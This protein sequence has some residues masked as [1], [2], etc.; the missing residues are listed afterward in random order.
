MWRWLSLKIAEVSGCGS[1]R[2]GKADPSRQS[3][4]KASEVNDGRKPSGRRV[5][6]KLLKPSDLTVGQKGAGKHMHGHRIRARGTHRVSGRHRRFGLVLAAF[7][8]YI[9][10]GANGL[11]PTT[12][13]GMTAELSWNSV[14]GKDAE[15]SGCGSAR[16][17][18][19]DPS[20]QS[21]GKAS[22]VNDGR[23]PSGSSR[24]A[25]WGYMKQA[26]QCPFLLMGSD[27]ESVSSPRIGISLQT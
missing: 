4:G 14:T 11:A 9:T 22:V 17:G 21:D 2:N 27:F 16:N 10:L 15:V 7:L 23:K 25:C 5:N 1:A 12:S 26:R 18:K 3:D 13:G 20:R 24:L 8:G 6:R 19:A